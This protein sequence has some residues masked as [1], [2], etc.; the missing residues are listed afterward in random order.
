VRL[1]APDSSPSPTFVFRWPWSFAGHGTSL[2]YAYFGVTFCHATAPRRNIYALGHTCQQI[3]LET[4]DGAEDSSPSTERRQHYLGDAKW[5]W[6]LWLTLT[7]RDKSGKQPIC[8]LQYGHLVDFSKLVHLS[9]MWL[10]L[11]SLG[12]PGVLSNI[13][14]N[15]NRSLHRHLSG[16]IRA[17]RR[18]PWTEDE[19][20]RLLELRRQGLN[21]GRIVNEMDNRTFR[22]IDSRVRALA[23]GIAPRTERTLRSWSMEEEALLAEKYQ[24]GLSRQQLCSYLPGRTFHAICSKLVTMSR[25]IPIQKNPK[26]RRKPTDEDVQRMIHMRVKE[27]KSLQEIAAEFD[28]SWHSVKSMWQLRCVPIISQA[29]WDAVRSHRLWTPEETKHLFELHRRGTMT[30]REIALHFPSKSWDAV[31]TK[32]KC[33]NLSCLRKPTKKQTA[34]AP[35]VEQT[36]VASDNVV[37]DSQS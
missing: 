37:L 17:K 25:R 4:I 2:Q 24:Q 20:R 21:T 36:G 3:P 7:A 6:Q 10:S 29:A 26:R 23:G 22:S 14:C 30:R 1:P 27:A 13:V 32:L 5:R 31:R 9:K 34:S 19:D 11:A 33:E 16:Q 15:W 35:K 18:G 28:R 12:K 8:T